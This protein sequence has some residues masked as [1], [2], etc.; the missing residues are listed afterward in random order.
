MR[1]G[2]QVKLISKIRHVLESRTTVI[3][4]ILTEINERLIREQL[5][6]MYS[7]NN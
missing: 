7:R 3:A 1:K 2:S 4:K 5:K 6:H